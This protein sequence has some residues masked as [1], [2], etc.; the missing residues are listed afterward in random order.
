MENVYLQLITINVSERDSISLEKYEY[1]YRERINSFFF[2][3]RSEHWIWMYVR[4][5]RSLRVVKV[6]QVTIFYRFNVII[7]LS[8]N[9][10]LEIS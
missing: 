10:N 8:H 6:G 7:F 5:C 4:V 9:L 2:G 1:D 3:E